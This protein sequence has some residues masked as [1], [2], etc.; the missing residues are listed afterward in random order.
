VT[1]R[2]IALSVV[3]LAAV[4]AGCGGS[5]RP[6]TPVQK[7][8]AGLQAMVNNG[9]LG[10]DGLTGGSAAAIRANGTAADVAML[11]TAQKACNPLSPAQARQAGRAVNP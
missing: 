9:L 6:L 7:C 4:V 11:D 3:V 8:T 10:P 5:S 1:V 2:R